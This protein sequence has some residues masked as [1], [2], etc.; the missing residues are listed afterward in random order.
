MFSFT[1]YSQECVVLK[2]NTK[3]QHIE[4]KKVQRAFVGER[5]VYKKNWNKKLDV[6]S[7]SG[8]D[9]KIFKSNYNSK[10]VQCSKVVDR[11][12]KANK[13]MS[14]RDSVLKK[15]N[16]VSVDKGV[17]LKV[18]SYIK[19]KSKAYYRLTVQPK[20]FVWVSSRQLKKYFSKTCGQAVTDSNNLI[21]T[22]DQPTEGEAYDESMGNLEQS[23]K[24]EVSSSNE[25]EPNSDL[26]GATSHRNK[27]KGYWGF[28]GG[29][30]TGMDSSFLDDFIDSVDPS[31]VRSDPDPIIM[32]IEKGQGFHAHLFYER[33]FIYENM[34]LRLGGGY[35]FESYIMKTKLNPF[36]NDTIVLLDSLEDGELTVNLSAVDFKASLSYEINFWGLT[37]SPGFAMGINYYLNDQLVVERRIEANKVTEDKSTLSLNA[38]QLILMPQIEARL[39]MGLLVGLNYRYVLGNGGSIGAHLGYR[40]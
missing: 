9:Y 27:S 5:L 32:S 6:V 24:E 11:C 16:K 4:S 20:E 14:L 1:S 21:A 29:V 37:W 36:T 8:Q 30:D 40:F 22:Q 10:K 26:T 31:N 15:H 35:R 33:P 23:I 34:L 17:E 2:K 3:I 19:K 18:A 28:Y 25:E 38:V 12:F 39:K 13:S 7:L